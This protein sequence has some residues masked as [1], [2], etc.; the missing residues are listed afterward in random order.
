M[1]ART[2][3]AVGNA[4]VEIDHTG[5]VRGST[6]LIIANRKRPHD[7]SRARRKL[8]IPAD[9]EI[10]G[11]VLH[12][13]RAV[14]GHHD[15]VAQRDRSN[16]AVLTA[17]GIGT[18]LAAGEDEIARIGEGVF[19]ANTE[20]RARVEDRVAGVAH[21]HIILDG[22]AAV[23]DGLVGTAAGIRHGNTDDGVLGSG[24]RLGDTKGALGGPEEITGGGRREI[25]GE[26]RRVAERRT[27]VGIATKKGALID[28]LTVT[29][30][31]DG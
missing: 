14:S 20:K 31:A 8:D 29:D 6:G 1:I 26:D 3:G 17:G 9:A 11:A 12:L 18:E 22:A 23:V 5:V 16:H 24:E 4:S 10:V 30:G 21:R 19:G 7:A 28:V 2:A 25:A 15:G 13:N 27:E